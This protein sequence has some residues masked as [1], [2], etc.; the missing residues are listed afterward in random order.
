[1]STVTKFGLGAL[2][3]A[4]GYAGATVVAGNRVKTGL[5]A[6]TES[7]A[8]QLPFAKVLEQKYEKGLLSST[9]TTKLQLGCMQMPPD[10]NG[11]PRP[12]EPI[13]IT[14]RDHIQHGPLPGFKGVGAAAVDTEI[15]LSDSVQ[16]NLAQM[17][18]NEKPLTIHTLVGWDGGTKTQIASPKATFKD[19]KE[20]EVVWAGLTGTVTRS[21]AANG[22]GTTDVTIPSLQIKS[23]Q[24]NDHVSFNQMHFHFEGAG[25][26]DSL[27][28]G[29]GK[30]DGEL[31]SIEVQ[32]TPKHGDEAGEPLKGTIS[33]IKYHAENTIDKGFLQTKG[34]FSASAK[35]GELT[36]NQVLMDASIKNLHAETYARLVKTMMTQSL[37]CD[38]QDAQSPAQTLQQMQADLQPLL[39]YNPEYSLDRLLVEIDGKKGELSYSFGVQGATEADKQTPLPTLLMG[40]G[41]V[42][43]AAKLPLAWID[44]FAALKGKTADGEHGDPAAM[45][46]SMLE[47]FAAQGYVVLDQDTVSSNFKFGQGQIEVN[48]RPFTP[49][50]MP[51]HA[52]MGVP[53]PEVQPA[54]Q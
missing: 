16:K 47:Q 49:P 27:W 53:G 34:S 31:A 42:K 15:V 29:A 40:K 9:R 11:Q 1:M 14:W 54:Y 48:G 18:G 28:L 46:R 51:G 36:V 23:T 6:S 41:Y 8:K 50:G 32:I 26:M 35:F 44:K 38:E 52:P 45:A 39:A 3:V 22:P 25:G 20:G 7:I 43:G 37:S 12:R 10:A 21:G 24:G 5:E 4:A 19:P 2:V 13:V 33:N 17:F 30:G